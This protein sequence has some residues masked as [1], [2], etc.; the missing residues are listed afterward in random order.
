[1]ELD[2]SRTEL[3]RLVRPLID[4]CRGPVEQALRDAAVTR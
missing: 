1:L 4:R 2:L 3:E